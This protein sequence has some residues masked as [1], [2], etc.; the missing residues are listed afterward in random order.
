MVST[1]VSSVWSERLVLFSFLVVTMGATG[2]V[3]RYEVVSMYRYPVML[4][5]LVGVC[6]LI[7]YGHSMRQVRKSASE[8]FN[9]VI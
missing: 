6:V 3:F 8:R 7:K 2:A 4:I 5:G 1:V 9:G